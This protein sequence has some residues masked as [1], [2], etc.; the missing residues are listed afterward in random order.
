VIRKRE[1]RYSNY[2]C[3]IK[4]HSAYADVRLNRDKLIRDNVEKISIESDKYGPFT[5]VEMKITEDR[6]E[7]YDGTAMIGMWF[8]PKNTVLIQAR[9]AATGTKGLVE[10]IKTFG[11]EHGL[12]PMEEVLE[13]YYPPHNA[14]DYVLFVDNNN[15]VRNKLKTVEDKKMVGALTMEREVHGP[16]GLE[17]E[18]YDVHLTARIPG[19]DFDWYKRTR[20]KRMTL[21]EKEKENE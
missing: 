16:N 18:S 12:I 17:T 19:E 6:V 15:F 8:F 14:H 9:D 3:E 1:P 21:R 4:R 10:A 5:S 7:I 11:D 20:R 13:D 2:D